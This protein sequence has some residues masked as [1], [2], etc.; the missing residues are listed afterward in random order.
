M[1]FLN[2]IFVVLSFEVV[3]PR[4]P[5][6]PR[7]ELGEYFQ[8]LH[9]WNQFVPLI[10][11]HY[12]VRYSLTLISK[13]AQARCDYS[14]L[15]PDFKLF[16]FSYAVF[17]RIVSAET[18]LFWKW[19]FLQYGNFLLHK[20]NSCCGNYWREGGNYSRK[21]IIFRNAHSKCKNWCP[22]SNIFW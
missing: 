12:R 8:W 16:P 7:K 14:T 13:S 9:F 19:K 5:Q 20:L 4:R 1:T 21:D 22:S 2:R 6:C 15:I 17:P 3:W 18:F 11:M 10:K